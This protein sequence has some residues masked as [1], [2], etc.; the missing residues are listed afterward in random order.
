MIFFL[1]SA[2]LSFLVSLITNLFVYIFLPIVQKRYVIWDKCGISIAV[3]E[4]YK[5]QE[6]C[7][8]D[9]ENLF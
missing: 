6:L 1:K 3:P 7:I 5:E 8:G 9:M 2:E 4:N